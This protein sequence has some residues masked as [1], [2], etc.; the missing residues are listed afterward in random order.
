M[1][2][3]VEKELTRL[4]A[5]MAGTL[6]PNEEDKEEK[7]DAEEMVA[8]TTTETCT[9]PSRDFYL[10]SLDEDLRSGMTHQLWGV[11]NALIIA[12]FTD[13]DA[14]IAGFHPDYDSPLSLP[15]S[16]ALDVDATN[17]RLAAIGLHA[18]LVDPRAPGSPAPPPGS[19]G[20]LAS[21][22][23]CPMC[24]RSGGGDM[25]VEKSPP[26]LR[27]ALMV[28]ALARDDPPGAVDLGS[29]F[30]YPLGYYY[31]AHP[32]LQRLAAAVV[33]ALQPSERVKAEARRCAESAGLAEGRR[34]V[35][36]HL[37]LEDDWARHR[38]TFERSPDR[39]KTTEEWSRAAYAEFEAGLRALL[40]M[41]GDGFVCYVSTGLGKYPNANDGMLR[42]LREAFP[43][44]V[45]LAAT[46]RGRWEDAFPALGKGGGRELQA[47]VDY[48]LCRGAEG[49]VAAKGSS[50]SCNVALVMHEAGRVVVFD[51]F[52][53]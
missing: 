34:Y 32:V 10:T 38:V 39:G 42:R 51:P 6:P 26:E 53:W 19:G 17:A 30:I 16:A 41:K 24:S 27:F 44:G 36:I 9:P 2:T 37:R 7:E 40:E 4:A 21:R 11:A 33:S 1:E 13:R 20:W 22:H 25:W 52:C 50:F 49:F 35:A 15:I 23:P 29:T 5:V 48:T 31:S 3:W 46:E 14:C 12:H 47:L 45:V 18:M 28:E 8:T 43:P